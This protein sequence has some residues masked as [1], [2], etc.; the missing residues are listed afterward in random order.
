MAH[1]KLRATQKRFG[2]SRKWTQSQG[3]AQDEVE[4]LASHS[5]GSEGTNSSEELV[6]EMQES[7]LEYYESCEE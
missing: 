1:L 7:D 5:S 6:S 2:R 3:E 4:D